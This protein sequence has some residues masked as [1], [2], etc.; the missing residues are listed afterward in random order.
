M[1]SNTT[2]GGKDIVI[3]DV[4]HTEN[5]TTIEVL[6]ELFMQK[7]SRKNK[8]ID[9]TISSVLL[10]QVLDY[11]TLIIQDIPKVRIS[12]MD[13]NKKIETKES[14]TKGVDIIPNKDIECV[15]NGKIIKITK[16]QLINVIGIQINKDIQS[17]DRLSVDDYI[18]STADLHNLQTSGLYG[19]F[20]FF[21]D[22][23]NYLYIMG[24]NKLYANKDVISVKF[25]TDINKFLYN[26]FKVYS[27]VE[28]IYNDSFL[29]YKNSLLYIEAKKKFSQIFGYVS[30]KQK[31]YKWLISSK[32]IADTDMRYLN[33]TVENQDLINKIKWHGPTNIISKPYIEKLK[34][35]ILNSYRA[36]EE[37]IKSRKKKIEINFKKS[38]AYTKYGVDSLDKLSSNQLK[39]INQEYDAIKTKTKITDTTI[40][41]N[42][43]I[44]SVSRAI[45]DGADAYF[46]KNL[47]QVLKII[48]KNNKQGIIKIGSVDNI[49][50]HWIDLGKL[51]LNSP[52]TANRDILNE[53]SVQE[54]KSNTIV[55][56]L[57]DYCKICGA[58]LAEYD[59]EEISFKEKDS[60][61]MDI[62][63]DD[64]FVMVKKELQFV[65]DYYVEYSG[66]SKSTSVLIKKDMTNILH[67]II[68]ILSGIIRNKIIDIQADLIKIK[69][70]NENDMWI[71]TNIY[72]Y[73]YIFALLAQFIFTNPD[74]LKF[75][76]FKSSK[77]GLTNKSNAEFKEHT[78][79]S[80]GGRTV[81]DTKGILASLLKSKQSKANL[82]KIINFALELV[83]KIKLSD[84]NS[85]K[86]ITLNNVKDLFLAAYKWTLTLNY[87]VI[88]TTKSSM[89]K[90][91][92]LLELRNNSMAHCFELYGKL[93]RTYEQIEKDLAKS[94][95][96]YNT[97]HMESSA[98]QSIKLLGDYVLKERFSEKPIP[99]NTDMEKT[100][101]EFINA[102]N[103]E[104]A[105]HYKFK[106]TVI[107]PHIY[108]SMYNLPDD[109]SYITKLPFKLVASCKGCV[110]TYVYRIGKT[111]KELTKKDITNWLD[112]KEYTKLKELYA[113]EA[114]GSKCICGSKSNTQIVLF[115]KYFEQ[116]CPKGELHE[117]KAD[118]CT[119]CG[120][121]DAMI[122]SQ[123]LN[124]YNKW[125][126]LF[127]KQRNIE[128]AI[129]D[130]EMND[131]LNVKTEQYSKI[132][133]IPAWKIS[134]KEVTE[135]SKIFKIKN[136]YNLLS[137][138]GLYEGREYHKIEMNQ[139]QYYLHASDDEFK[140]QASEIHNYILY[141]YQNYYTTKNSEYLLKIPYDLKNLLTKMSQNNRDFSKKLSDIK[142]RYLEQYNYYVEQD[143]K[144]SLLANFAVASL[145]D[146]F[147][148]IYKNFQQAK[149]EKFG[150][151]WCQFYIAKIIGFE[152]EMC[153]IKLKS[154]KPLVKYQDEDMAEDTRLE[155]TDMINAD[156]D[157]DR[158]MVS[159]S[160]AEEYE[161]TGNAFALD[162]VD[163][164]EDMEDNLYD[165]K[166]IEGE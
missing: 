104:K 147:L 158:V 146:L 26:F 9:S 29:T 128:K 34:M 14:H 119:K 160:I 61:M 110:K 38:T 115:F 109:K 114:L 84:I 108:P 130:K 113:A 94:V 166:I 74:I 140:L 66:E 49:C 107:K 118:K 96:V 161:E 125:K 18:A 36:N 33:W 30:D 54:S 79:S 55:R 93:G 127:I 60:Y 77:G 133:D 138:I 139:V 40:V 121:T 97:A 75:K 5:K 142:Q 62:E 120:V 71:L 57:N 148:Q 135:L 50:S 149:L 141:I 25:N 103:N 43:Y 22:N 124:Y 106:R 162:D 156:A 81:S 72:I 76:V 150:Y 159:D 80:K 98:P 153:T 105:E 35:N 165:D 155:D 100:Y 53:Y 39:L 19:V 88:S 64:I 56:D 116:Y 51:L 46:K 1:I 82:E 144:P 122:V 151:T 41:I 136:L 2:H 102:T 101:Q 164:D 112:N 6:P 27:T 7:L 37:L 90:I 154:L 73:I 78:V 59:D 69:T 86:Y 3:F 157:D 13:Y 15:H 99:E 58:L 28:N 129:I 111:I 85:S 67:N 123:D 10:Q 4:G 45:K 32:I 21:K 89:G 132:S 163:V 137:T 17:N 31:T 91:M 42:N 145:A 95:S 12:Y 52:N 117:Y 63:D 134:N 65:L 11:C 126:D 8:W 44:I 152:K 92:P 23:Y 48:P 143:I 70:M 87:D 131:R 68:D 20:N 16:N 24:P 83:K 47:E